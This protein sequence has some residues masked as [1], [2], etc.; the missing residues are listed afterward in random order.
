M[1]A[2]RGSRT[3]FA[4]RSRTALRRV[5]VPCPT[6]FR[7]CGTVREMYSGVQFR[8]FV[9]TP[10]PAG[11]NRMPRLFLPAASI[12]PSDNSAANGQGNP[13][14]SAM[15]TSNTWR[16]AV[17]AVALLLV[18]MPVWAAIVLT[19]TGLVRGSETKDLFE[20]KGIPFAAP[21]VGM[22]RW[23]EP[24]PATPWQGVRAAETFAPACMQT[25]VSMPGETPPTV[26]ED[27]LYLN[28]W[29]PAP[30]R[31]GAA[32]DGVD[33]WRRF[34]RRFGL[35]AALLGRP[36]RAQRRH[37]R[38]V[39]LSRGAVRISRAS[40]T[41]RSLRTIHPATMASRIRSRLS[42]G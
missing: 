24:Q 36:A 31:G 8:P 10:T 14:G 33:L 7:P 4:A 11:A 37:R 20:F 28:I 12:P 13:K 15:T 18:P 2:S 27:C 3:R 5:P 23:R 39:R 22:L 21:P 26:S 19:E 34:L 9:P 42:H 17:L 1:P 32:G 29:A 16:M 40:R 38:H 25:G 30:R 35:D 6:G 41:H